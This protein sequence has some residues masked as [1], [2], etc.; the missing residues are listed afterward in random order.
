MAL[1]AG[2]EKLVGGLVFMPAGI[3]ADMA[4]VRKKK[5]D[6]GRARSVRQQAALDLA[7]SGKERGL[8]LTGPVCNS[9]IYLPSLLD[10]PLNLRAQPITPFPRQS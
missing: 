4:V 7:R 9:A 6:I 8:E 5:A 1:V 10:E 2:L 3:M